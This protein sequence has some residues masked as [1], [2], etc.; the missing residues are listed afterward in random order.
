MSRE[1]LTIELRRRQLVTDTGNVV[2]QCNPDG[3][4]E[5]V[6]GTVDPTWVDVTDY[7]RG[8]DK[9][10]L[11]WDQV[12]SGTSTNSDTNPGGSNYGKGLSVELTF[13]DLAYEFIRDWLDATSC[14]TLNAVEVRITDQLCDRRYRT[15]EVKA[16]NLSE[17]PFG[18][19]CEY[20]V[21]LREADPVW[22]CVHKTFIWDNWQHWFEDGST[23]QHPC[24]LT[25]VEPRPRLVNSARFGFAML[26][27]TTPVIQ[28]LGLPLPGGNNVFRRI[29]NLDNFVDSPLIRDIITNACDKCGL[30]YDTIFHDPASPYYNLCLYYPLSGAVHVNET[31]SVVANA[32]WFHFENRWNVTL[33]E[34]LD[35]LKAVFEGEWYVTPNAT[36]VFRAKITSLGAPAIFDFVTRPDVCDASTL[37]YTSN[38]DKKPAYGRYQYQLDGGDLATNEVLPLYNDIVDYDGPA[39]NLMLEG[40]RSK[41]FEFAST[42]F[43]R[44]GR[45]RGDYTRDIV[46]DGEIVGYA[47]IILLVVIVASLIGGLL[48]AG[49]G[50]ILGAYLAVWAVNIAS[51]ASDLR[52]LFASS[53]YTGAVRLTVEEV[54]QP[55]LLLW[56]GVSMNRAK[57]VQVLP[58]DIAPNLYYNPGAE[59]YDTRNKF[60]YNPSGGLKIFNYPMYLESYFEDNLFDRFHDPVDNPL[61]SRE[62]N[63]TFELE[64]DLCCELGDL[65]GFWENSYARIGDIVRLEER[66]GYDVLGRIEHFDVSHEDEK[67]ILRG[68]VLNS[69]T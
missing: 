4:A 47:V 10:S 30:A 66:D 19:P 2:V 59:P 13:N 11:S 38:A 44:D 32:L 60:L 25:G 27:Q 28:G 21:A 58:E 9:L 54:G 3:T 51:K 16:D 63:R 61:R 49:A 17:A 35:K 8:L 34:L 64:A 33:A 1:R 52:D 12:N 43:V 69:T 39:N 14:S 18:R 48:S 53:T 46:N 56:D 26:W 22:H 6:P 68:K 45:A 65:L 31:S 62:R 29:L 40:S 37:E 20:T 5:Y 42:G 50:A 67:I 57:V 55:R 41:S 23:K 36:L 24:F 7:T 15:F